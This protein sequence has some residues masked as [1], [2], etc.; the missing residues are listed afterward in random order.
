MQ[1]ARQLQTNKRKL[2]KE[3]TKSERLFETKL[4]ETNIKYKK[5]MILGFFILDFCLPDHMINFEID[6][7]YH[8]IQPLKDKLRDRFVS[9][10]GYSVIRVKNKDVKKYD[11]SFLKHFCVYDECVFRS[12][13]AK[14]NALRGNVINKKYGE[15]N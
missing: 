4:K 14:A 6:G 5:Q 1:T 9:N 11:L 2:K 13:L 12:S 8:E 15:E 7:E 10:C 3:M